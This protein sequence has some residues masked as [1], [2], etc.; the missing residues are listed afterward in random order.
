MKNSSPQLRWGGCVRSDVR[1][2]EEPDK[3]TEVVANRQEWKGINAVRC[4]AA[5]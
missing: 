4:S 2:T 1:K 5:V 3:W